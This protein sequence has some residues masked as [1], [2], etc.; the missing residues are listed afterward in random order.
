F[1]SDTH[2]VSAGA[3]QEVDS[4]RGVL[5]ERRIHL[6]RK[7][8]LESFLLYIPD[9]S[10]D[11]EPLLSVGRNAGADGIGL[12]PVP[13]RYG[14]VDHGYINCFVV[15]EVGE[16][17]SAKQRDPKRLEISRTDGLHVRPWSCAIF[18]YRHPFD[19]ER[20]VRESTFKR[21]SSR[22][23]YGKDAVEVAGSLEQRSIEL[24][25]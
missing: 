11:R 15:I 21:N 7:F 6:V 17:P 20:C 8:F 24:P 4:E 25:H 3:D 23:C 19:P 14:L 1:P 13:S 9:H 22:Q 2:R 16:R 10:D 12:G 18:G 5:S